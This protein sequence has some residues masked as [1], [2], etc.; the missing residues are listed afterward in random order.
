[1]ISPK[2]KYVA[3]SIFIKTPIGSL[4]RWVRRKTGK[5]DWYRNRK[6]WDAELAGPRASYLKGRGVDI[7]NAVMKV[8]IEQNAPYARTL[9]DVGCARGELARYLDMDVYTGIDISDYAIE[10]A[11]KYYACREEQRGK[12]ITFYCS[13]M[14]EYVP[15]Q[16]E[17]YDLIVFNEILYYLE[18]EEALEQV[19]RYTKYLTPDGMLI[20]S[21]K[22]DPKAEEILKRLLKQYSWIHGLLYQENLHTAKHQ[23]IINQERPAFLVGLLKIQ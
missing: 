1:M 17:L 11:N 15:A 10:E 14:C 13:D 18:I 19:R 9:L 2:L 12:R 7:S 23:I 4:G 8:L 16:N 5:R 3:K 21:L 20:V 6:Y 22:K